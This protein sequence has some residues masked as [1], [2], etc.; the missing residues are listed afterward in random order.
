M[1]SQALFAEISSKKNLTGG[2]LKRVVFLL[3]MTYIVIV[4][5]W[6]ITEKVISFFTQINS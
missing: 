1:L 6:V 4:K 2:K 5:G 3:I